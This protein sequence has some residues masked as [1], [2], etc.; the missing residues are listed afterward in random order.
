MHQS[1][2]QHFKHE[3]DFK[4]KYRFYNELEGGQKQLLL[5]QKATLLKA[6]K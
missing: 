4:V 1:Y 3:S 2:E 5:E 6:R